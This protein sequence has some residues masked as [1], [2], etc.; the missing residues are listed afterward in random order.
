M[1]TDNKSNE[2]LTVKVVSI[3][4]KEQ[5]AEVITEM[6]VLKDINHNSILK[7]F[8]FASDNQYYYIVSE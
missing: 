3:A 1:A 6:A 4:S 5:T 7:I 2:K 8:E